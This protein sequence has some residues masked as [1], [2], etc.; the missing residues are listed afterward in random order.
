M[1]LPTIIEAAAAGTGMLA[2]LGG[3]VYGL[4]KFGAKVDA[5]TVATEKL[6][7]AFSLQT[8]S[9]GNTLTDH[10]VRITVLEKGKK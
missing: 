9:V 6:T 8:E 3:A 4:G 1:S 5:N 2:F 10:E 7:E